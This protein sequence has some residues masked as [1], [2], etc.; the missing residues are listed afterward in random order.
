MR[1]C[2]MFP[3]VLIDAPSQED[4]I[5]KMIPNFWSFLVQLLALIVMVIVVFFVAYKPV[6]KMIQ[7]RQNYIEQNIREAAENNEK[8]RQNELASQ[9]LIL[10]SQS[11]ANSIIQNAKQVA[12][13]EQKKIVEQT[14]L[15]IQKM[16]SDAEKEI[17]QK[18][19]EAL[20]SIRHEMIDVALSASSELLKRNVTSDDNRR[21]V[22]EFIEEVEKK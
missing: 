12:A 7:K 17:V 3:L 10:D 21:L 9:Q 8:S 6:K 16:K 15:D 22:K 1:R 14:Q 18:Q 4:F 13:V 5:S 2:F 19:E 11:K 20:E